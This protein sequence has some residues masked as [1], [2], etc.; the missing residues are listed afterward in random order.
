M[1]K[2]NIAGFY[3]KQVELGKN[4]QKWGSMLG[5]QFNNMF[6]LCHKKL[7]GVLLDLH[8][9]IFHRKGVVSIVT[10]TLHGSILMIPLR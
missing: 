10:T 3:V 1:R 2:N 6:N 4:W 5:V 8:L 7:F 9:L